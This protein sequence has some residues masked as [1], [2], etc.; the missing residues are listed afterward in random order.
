MSDF[1]IEGC[2]L[3]KFNGKGNW[4]F[5]KKYLQA[6]VSFLKKLYF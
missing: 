1:K 5:L 3:D 4:T 2:V 6:T